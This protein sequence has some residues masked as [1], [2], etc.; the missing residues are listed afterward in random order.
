LKWTSLGILSQSWPKEQAD[1]WQAGMGVSREVLEKL[2]AEKRTKEADAF[3]AQ[4]NDAVQRDCVV[5][6]D[7]TGDAEIDIMVQDPTGTVC[8]LRN[9]RTTA[10]GVLIGNA[11]RQTEHDDFGGH[12]EAYVCSK[13]FDGAYRVLIRRVWGNLTTGKVNVQ[14]ITHFRGKGAA[15]LRKKIS[16]DKDE[17]LVVFNLKGG[18]RTEQL[19]EEQVAQAIDDQLNLNRQI[20]GQQLA[21]AI[22][23]AAMMGMAGSRADAQTV[24]GT[25]SLLGAIGYEPVIQW[26]PKGAYMMATAVVSA[27][28]R[29]VRITA[30]PM[31]TGVSSVETFNMSTGQT[32]STNQ[33]TGG[34]GGSGP[35]G[36]SGGTFGGSGGGSF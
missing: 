25:G 8:S 27:D 11:L 29:Y 16:L 3:L 30:M 31:F 13:G 12:S 18:R 28:R 20:L 7:W 6:A 32:G 17:A 34:Y 26:F 24:S 9:P 36:G 14:V 21:A 10:G 35:G 19:R 1:I 4:L 23:P 2:R 5:I 15:D 22:D 33:G